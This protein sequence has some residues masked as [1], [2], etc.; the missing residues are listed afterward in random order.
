[1]KDIRGLIIIAVTGPSSE[2]SAGDDTG[3]AGGIFSKSPTRAY[4]EGWD[5]IFGKAE[6]KTT[7]AKK[8]LN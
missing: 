2:A 6:D 5:R 3:K 8:D 4:S 7:V 1:M